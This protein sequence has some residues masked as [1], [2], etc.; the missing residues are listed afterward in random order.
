MNQSDNIKLPSL[1]NVINVLALPFMI[2]LIAV[3]APWAVINSLFHG[4][5][6][7]NYLFLF[8]TFLIIIIFIILFYKLAMF[9]ALKLGGEKIEFISRFG[10]NHFVF[11][12]EIRQIN[13]YK[14]GSPKILRRCKSKFRN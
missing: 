4:F 9:K 3:F 10:E 5:E 7:E 1:Y 6:L 14:N 8:I 2:M 13:Y 12:N 11:M